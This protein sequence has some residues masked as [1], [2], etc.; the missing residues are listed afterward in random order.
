MRGRQVA[1][2]AGATVS[3]GVALALA[4]VAVALA[5]AAVALWREYGP[6]WTD[7]AIYLIL[8]VPAL[9]AVLGT[10]LLLRSRRE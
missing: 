9:P 5:V 8:A 4:V 2:V 7:P 6:L 10:W 3:F 1:L